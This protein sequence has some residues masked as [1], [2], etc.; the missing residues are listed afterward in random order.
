MKALANCHFLQDR[1][2]P[3]MQITHRLLFANTTQ[4][5]ETNETMD[6][7]NNRYYIVDVTCMVVYFFMMVP[8]IF[9]N[10]LVLR[11]ISLFEHLHSSTHILIGSLATAGECH[12]T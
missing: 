7:R 4:R 10:G 1:I 12:S 6:D 11:T 5:D 8:I 9:G 2:Q 3:L